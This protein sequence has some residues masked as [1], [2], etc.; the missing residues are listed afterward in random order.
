MTTVKSACVEMIGPSGGMDL[1][2]DSYYDPANPLPIKC[3]HCTFPDLD[4]IA[5][6]YLLTKGIS[7]PAETSPA[8]VGNFLVRE[9]V[10]RILELVVPGACTFHPTAE[11]KNKKSA[12]W[13]LAVPVTKLNTPIA[14]APDPYCS[15]CHEPRWWSC[16]KDN[17]SNYD[18]GGVDI[19]KSLEWQ[20]SGTAEESFESTNRSRKESNIPPLPWSHYGVAAPSHPE[21]WTRTGLNRNLYF[22]VRLEQLFK[23]A[24]IKGQL[25]RYAN[26]KDVKPSPEDEAWIEEKLELLA[27]SGL[28]D[29]PKL[30]ASKTDNAA[31]KWFKQFL[32]K[33]AVNKAQAIDFASVE[34]ERTLIL[35]QDY[36][37]FATAVG[38]KSFRDVCDMEGSTTT[39]L[40]PEQLDFENY[41]RGKLP[42]LEGDDAEVDGVMFAANDGGD[43]FVFDVSAKGEWPVFWYQHE[44]NTM[45]SF[46]PNF[47]V[48]IKRFAQKN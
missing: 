43:C 28:V 44:E 32:K 31:Q 23:R 45:E 4:F 33:H 10:R 2:G 13:W 11:R 40:L 8:R 3:S 21:R 12:P 48:C 41:R 38:A 18:A 34:K 22:S 19:F 6:P 27:Q 14:K 20:S 16:A 35:P 47:A 39:I 5:K 9:R 46:A 15:K 24:K 25:V 26:F 1:M 29:G 30:V 36:K 37:D 17:M 7:S 42:D